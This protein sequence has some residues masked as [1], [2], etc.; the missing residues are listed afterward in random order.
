MSQPEN[1]KKPPKK[2]Q[3]TIREQCGEDMVLMEQRL[4]DKFT[5]KF[6]RFEQLL[7]AMA[8]PPQANAESNR[9]GTDLNTSQDGGIPV[10]E[11]TPG[12][13]KSPPG[14]SNT[15]PVSSIQQDRIDLHP[16]TTAAMNATSNNGIC[17]NVEAALE[18]PPFQVSG[19]TSQV[20]G[21]TKQP[22]DSTL[23]PNENNNNSA[24]W[25]L[26]QAL[27]NNS[28]IGE[29]YQDILP[30]SA[31]D[32]PYDHNMEVKVNQILASTAHHW[33]RAR[34]RLECFLIVLYLEGGTGNAQVSICYQCLNTYDAFL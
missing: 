9:A 2:K 20:S 22:D 5:E 24:A 21:S 1:T 30:I 29:A 11:P 17:P 19:T 27:D 26:S 18:A 23:T 12:M 7:T 16:R 14:V 8:K 6:D 34:V 10:P 25:I 32:V 15:R 4:T 28:A 13:T 3:K 31:N 33:L